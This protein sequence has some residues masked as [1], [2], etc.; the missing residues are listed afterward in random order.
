MKMLFAFIILSIATFTASA[1]TFKLSW[2]PPTHRADDTLLLPEE[3]AGYKFML[4]D[5]IQEPMLTDGKN[6]VTVDVLPGEQC[7]QLATVDTGGRESD[8]T[9]KKCLIALAPPG[10]AGN[11]TLIRVTVEIVIP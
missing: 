6:T 2:T 8:W 3:I 9:T 4:N 10:E 7:A 11:L 1:D 5:V